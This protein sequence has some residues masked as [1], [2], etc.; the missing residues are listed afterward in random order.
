[1]KVTVKLVPRSDNLIIENE[2][3]SA[4]ASD[5]SDDTADM[6]VRTIMN[7][8]NVGGS[9]WVSCKEHDSVTLLRG[10]ESDV[11]VNSDK[12]ISAQFPFLGISSDNT[13]VNQVGSDEGVC[14]T[15]HSSEAPEEH[16]ATTCSVKSYEQVDNRL[17]SVELSERVDNNLGTLMASIIID[18]S[19]CTLKPDVQIGDGNFGTEELVE[20]VDSSTSTLKT[21]DKIDNSLFAMR[22]D[23]LV[24]DSMCTV[25]LV[26][27]I[28]NNSGAVVGNECVDDNLCVMKNDDH[29][30]NCFGMMKVVDCVDNTSGTVELDKGMHNSLSSQK[31]DEQASNCLRAMKPNGVDDDNLSTVKPAERIVNNLSTV[32]PDDQVDKS[33]QLD[34]VSCSLEYTVRPL[35]S[36]LK[37]S[38]W[39]ENN[40]K[41]MAH[42]TLK[43]SWAATLNPQP[44]AKSNTSVL[45]ATGPMGNTGYDRD[46]LL[47]SSPR[48]SF[49]LLQEPLPSQTVTQEVKTFLQQNPR[50]LTKEGKISDCDNPIPDILNNNS[51]RI[52]EVGVIDSSDENRL[53]LECKEDSG[54]NTRF[55]EDENYNVPK[56]CETGCEGD[57]NRSVSGTLSCRSFEVGTSTGVSEI[58]DSKYNFN[59]ND[60]QDKDTVEE[61]DIGTCSESFRLA[62][63]SGIVSSMSDCTAEGSDTELSIESNATKDSPTDGI[64]IKPV[65][66]WKWDCEQFGVGIAN[67]SAENCRLS[68]DNSWSQS[69]DSSLVSVKTSAPVVQLT[70]S[71]SEC[72]N[73]KMDTQRGPGAGSMLLSDHSGRY[74]KLH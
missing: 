6:E 28:D 32:T 65:T 72:S 34:E 2:C 30:D 50:L 49:E 11:A 4:A 39:V 57:R 46:V 54:C 42:H 47:S 71:S 5:T 18:K 26:Q 20:Q 36:T 67:G 59:L 25:K 41:E 3:S 66:C 48:R 15:G 55:C 69:C 31:F 52:K 23:E 73:Y 64:N 10:P 60:S 70:G 63:S 12:D 33:L 45:Q 22:P 16:N 58:Y 68:N 17:G 14:M 19:L 35:E 7:A 62:G 44:V 21:T 27:Q 9:S 53:R 1:V 74:N 13:V 51:N 8:C 56:L 38:E 29:A 43:A 37:Q 61:N 24:G 40:V